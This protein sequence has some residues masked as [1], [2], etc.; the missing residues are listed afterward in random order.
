LLAHASLIESLAG[1]ASEVGVRIRHSAGLG[2]SSTP[3][4]LPRLGLLALAGVSHALGWSRLGLGRRLSTA[5]TIA[6]AV[7]ATARLG[8]AFSAA[9]A[10]ALTLGSTAAAVALAAAALSTTSLAAATLMSTASATRARF[11]ARPSLSLG[12]LGRAHERR[13]DG[14]DRC[15]EEWFDAHSCGSSNTVASSSGRI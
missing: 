9:L 15:H 12:A 6:I 7:V 4:L 14:H 11:S 8:T 5:S 1:A 13:R 2:R 3:G 10:S